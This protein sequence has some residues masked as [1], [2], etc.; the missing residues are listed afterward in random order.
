MT[1]V[2]MVGE[3]GILGTIFEMKAG[4]RGGDTVMMVMRKITGGFHVDDMKVIT[5]G[6]TKAK[7][8]DMKVPGGHLVCNACVSCFYHIPKFDF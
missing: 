3:E 1:Q 5:M 8:V 7:E 2:I 6:N 4:I